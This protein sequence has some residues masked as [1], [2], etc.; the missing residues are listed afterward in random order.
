MIIILKDVDN[1]I[2]DHTHCQFGQW[3]AS[4]G[5]S[6]YKNNE[7]YRSIQKPHALV[8]TSIINVIELA[9]NN[10]LMNNTHEVIEKFKQAEEA[11]LEMF[12]LMDQ[13]NTV[14]E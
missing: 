9:R 3:Y 5:Q 4:E 8:H 2:S 13:L 6:F 1:E 12:Q 11:S 10:Q 7:N 14:D